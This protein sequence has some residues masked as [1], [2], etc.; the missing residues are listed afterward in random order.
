VDVGQFSRDFVNAFGVDAEAL[1]GGQGFAGDFEQNAFEVGLFN[2]AQR[3]RHQKTTS[4][5][6]RTTN[7]TTSGMYVKNA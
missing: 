5:T 1:V 4:P 6:K 7:F 2:L 3:K